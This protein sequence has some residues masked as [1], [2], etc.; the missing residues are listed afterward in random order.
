MGE[1][2]VDDVLG[3]DHRGKRAAGG[4]DAADAGDQQVSLGQ[5]E[6]WVKPERHDG[7]CGARGSDAADEAENTGFAEVEWAVACR[8]GQLLGEVFALAPV[9]KFAREGA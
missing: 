9:V 4:I 1:G 5:I 8:E 3:Q 2:A 7:G 6:A